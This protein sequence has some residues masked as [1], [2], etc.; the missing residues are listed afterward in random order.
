MCNG[1]NATFAD[2]EKFR[3]ILSKKNGRK[4]RP[5]YDSET[6][7]KGTGFQ[8]CGPNSDAWSDRLPPQNVEAS[9][10]DVMKGLKRFLE[11]PPRRKHHKPGVGAKT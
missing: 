10:T 5:E 7:S 6:N 8:G 2:I 4:I 11:S 1:Q 3:D 9:A